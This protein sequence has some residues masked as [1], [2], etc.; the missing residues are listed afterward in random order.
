[1]NGGDVRT[2]TT[3]T[4]PSS[5][6]VLNELVYYSGLATVP[7]AGFPIPSELQFFVVPM[8][9]GTPTSIPTL[10]GLTPVGEDNSTLFLSGGAGAFDRWSPPSGVPMPV[11][12][13]QT[14]LVDGITIQGDYIYLAAQDITM[15]GFSNG[16]IARVPK[17]GG[18][19]ERLVQSIGHPWLVTA[20]A[21]GLYWAEDPMGITGEGRLVRS[22]LDGTSPMTLRSSE[23]L[24]SLVVSNGR[25][26]YSVGTEIDSMSAAGGP[27]TVIASGLKDAGLLSIVGGNIVWID[28]AQP[29]FGSTISPV[30]MTACLSR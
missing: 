18:R 20:D 17:A 22:N 13:D 8:A 10:M 4:S 16:L 6:I 2:L 23:S 21:Q 24:V 12:F 27:V 29:T 28:P 1:M 25:L 9:G 5:A 3:A 30:V 11:P 26:Y 19:L 15:G 7:D 14:L